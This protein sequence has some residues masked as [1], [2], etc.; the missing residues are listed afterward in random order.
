MVRHKAASAAV[1]GRSSAIQKHRKRGRPFQ[2][3]DR[4]F[5]PTTELVARPAVPKSK[6]KTILEWT[7]NKNKKK[8]L[9]LEVGF[10]RGVFAQPCM[11]DI[12]KGDHQQKSECKF[13][14][15]PYRKS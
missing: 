3:R 8:K 4:P 6:H 13:F 12:I 5:I 9:E 15:C 10:L 2:D 7:E 1:A 11:T 14:I